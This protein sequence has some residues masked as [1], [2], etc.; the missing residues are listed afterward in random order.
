[1]NHL[2]FLLL[3]LAEEASEVA[4]AI[5]E[6]KENKPQ[7]FLQGSDLDE[8]HLELND[9]YAVVNLLNKQYNFEY[10]IP[11]FSAKFCDLDMESPKFSA[12]LFKVIKQCHEIGKITAKT[13][14]FG[15]LERHPDLDL[16]NKQ[17]IHE[18]LNKLSNHIINLNEFWAFGFELSQERMSY[19]AEKI[20]FYLNYSIDLG[21]VKMV[22]PEDQ[23]LGVNHV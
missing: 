1:M 18:E 20:E 8:I 21:C 9:L 3:K 14:Q 6:A 12:L 11:E 7:Q 13:I 15:L 4:I 16:N 2:Q 19:K 17:R 23:F 22:V 5:I 10:R